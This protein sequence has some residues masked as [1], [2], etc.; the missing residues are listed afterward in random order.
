MTFEDVIAEILAQNK[1]NYEKE[2]KNLLPDQ[3]SENEWLYQTRNQ[4]FKK[5]NENEHFMKKCYQTNRKKRK[6]FIKVALY[7]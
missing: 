2:I 4:I 7:H 5:L 3:S 6:K 1:E